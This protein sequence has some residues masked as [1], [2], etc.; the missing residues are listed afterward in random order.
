MADPKFNP[1]GSMTCTAGQVAQLLGLS[2]TTFDRRRPELLAAGFPDRLPGV[3]KWSRPAVIAW[4]T[5]N[6]RTDGGQEPAADLSRLEIEY[7]GTAT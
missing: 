6:G 2:E 7:A 1:D 5:R 4:I 3:G